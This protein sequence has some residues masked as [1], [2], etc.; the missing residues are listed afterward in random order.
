MRLLILL[1]LSLSM[2]SATAQTDQVLWSSARVSYSDGD[3]WSYGLRPIARYNQGLRNA[4]DLSWDINA[5][6]KLSDKW[7]VNL[8]ERYWIVWESTNRNF[9]FIDVNFQEKNLIP[10]LTINQ[11]L[12][13]HWAQDIKDRVDGDFLRYGLQLR[14]QIPRDSD[15]DNLELRPYIATELFFRVDGIQQAQ[16]WRNQLGLDVVLSPQ[17]KVQLAYWYED[18][19][20]SRFDFF[21]IFVVTLDYRLPKK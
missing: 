16:R 18:F 7:S 14:P 20:N 4:Q 15:P 8:L 12:R 11:R 10:R 2:H 6:Y 1:Y 3:K 13:V 21:D 17:W 5:R 19:V 9:I